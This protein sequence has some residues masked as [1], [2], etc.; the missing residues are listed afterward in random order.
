MSH[1]RPSDEVLERENNGISMRQVGLGRWESIERLFAGAVI[2]CFVRFGKALRVY[3][4]SPVLKCIGDRASA[5]G[6]NLI[7]GHVGRLGAGLS[8]KWNVLCA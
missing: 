3:D 5:Q 1:A 8:K 7:R 4:V 6:Q 2:V